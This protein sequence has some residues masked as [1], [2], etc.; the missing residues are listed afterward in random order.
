MIKRHKPYQFG[1]LDEFTSVVKIRKKK[2]LTKQSPCFDPKEEKTL[3]QNTSITAHKARHKLS[4][5]T[6]NTLVKARVVISV[7]Q[8]RRA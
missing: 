7:P 1:S 4:F 5:T 6:R 8:S 2:T 3:H